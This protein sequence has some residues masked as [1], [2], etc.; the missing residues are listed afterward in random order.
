MTEIVELGA[1]TMGLAV[2][3]VGAVHFW[4][5][6]MEKSAEGHLKL[7]LWLELEAAA[8]GVLWILGLVSMICDVIN[9][10][11]M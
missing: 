8:V 10:R 1:K 11:L 6:G 9:G 7:A 2:L 3:F 4:A 5:A